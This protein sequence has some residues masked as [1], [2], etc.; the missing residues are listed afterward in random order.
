[1][2]ETSIFVQWLSKPVQYI[3]RIWKESR[4]YRLIC[5]IASWFMNVWHNS[6]IINWFK[7]DGLLVRCWQHSAILRFT[8]WLANL[9]PNLLG[10]LYARLENWFRNSLIFR[11]LYFLS[12][13]LP[14]LIALFVMV[15]MIVPYS[16]WNN[17]YSTMA[18]LVFLV[19][20]LVRSMKDRGFRFGVEKMD[21]YLF[22]FLLSVLIAQAFSVYPGLSLRFL[23][24]YAT[25]FLLMLMLVSSIRSKKELSDVL[26]IIMIGVALAGLYGVYQGIRGVPV[27]QSQVDVDL[28]EG[29]P[30]RVYSFMGNSNI[31]AQIIVMFVPFFAA[32]VLSARGWQKKMLFTVA[33]IPSFIALLMT[34]SRSGYVGLA[35]AVF[36]FVFLVKRSLVP[37]FIVLGILAVPFLPDTVLRRISTIT[38]LQDS[39]ITYRFDIFES[40]WMVIRDFWYTGVGLGSDAVQRVTQNYQYLTKSAPLHSHNVYLQ[41]WV[42][43]GIVGLISFIGWMIRTVKKSLRVVYDTDADIYLRMVLIAGVSGLTGILAI[44]LVE[45]IWYYPRAMMLFWIFIGI[46]AAAI[47][48]SACKSAAEEG[49]DF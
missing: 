12:E 47:R 21:L 7:K 35:I 30:G 17:R 36:V 39:S 23:V 43:T 33:A 26:E 48:L 45:Y 2:F 40:M 14:E 16:Y 41:V 46:M 6:L 3:I 11:L 34:Y 1:M 38:N 8:D 9:I 31:F 15:S 37:F 20:F 32:V 19:L 25:D 4:T 5:C 27:N 28:N 44:G 18:M 24:F 22:L 13:H 10:R 42:E 29:M 49:R